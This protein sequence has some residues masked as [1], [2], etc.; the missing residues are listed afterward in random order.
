[1]VTE[2]P[3]NWVFF[4]KFKQML[5]MKKRLI[6]TNTPYFPSVNVYHIQHRELIIPHPHP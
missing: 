4:E 2:N 5:P 6:S 3:K 1:M